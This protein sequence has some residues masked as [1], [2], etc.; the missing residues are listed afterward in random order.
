M[1][2]KIS[3]RSYNSNLSL[4]ESSTLQF[5]RVEG[6]YEQIIN[7]NNY[8]E[9]IKAFFKNQKV[10]TGL[11]NML[12]VFLGILAT[13]LLDIDYKFNTIIIPVILYTTKYINT[14]L[15]A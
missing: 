15:S 12:G 9:K 7:K 5:K 6:G 1:C 3:K 2:I 4:S 10:R 14:R 11:W 13:Y 8:M